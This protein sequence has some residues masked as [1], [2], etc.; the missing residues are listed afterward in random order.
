MKRVT[1]EVL[2]KAEKVRMKDWY[3]SEAMMVTDEKNKATVWMSQYKTRSNLEQY[4]KK[5]RIEVH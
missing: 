4:M 1:D 5:L 2:G 3:D